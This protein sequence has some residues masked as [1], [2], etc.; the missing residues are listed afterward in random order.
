MTIQG[1]KGTFIGQISH[2]ST[3]PASIDETAKYGLNMVTLGLTPT[4]LRNTTAVNALLAKAKGYGIKVQFS[5]NF[6]KEL[7]SDGSSGSFNDIQNDPVQ[8][9]N[10]MSTIQF[11]LDN[12]SNMSNSN[13]IAG[14]EL[15]EP[16]RHF[17]ITCNPALSTYTQ[18]MTDNRALMDFYNTMFLEIKNKI[19]TARLSA[20][21][22]YGFNHASS[23]ASWPKMGTDAAFI[24]ANK[25]FTF[26]SIQGASDN[27]TAV[28]DM[29]AQIRAALTYPE[30]EICYTAMLT[31]STFLKN[32]WPGYRCGASAPGTDPLSWANP[33]CWN[34]LVFEH[35]KYCALNN[36]PFS[37]FI[38]ERF[39]VLREYWTAKAICSTCEQ[40]YYYDKPTLLP[41]GTTAGEI[42]KSIINSS[43]PPCPTLTLGAITIDNITCPSPIFTGTHILNVIPTGGQGTLKYNWTVNNTSIGTSQS[44]S[45]N[46]TIDGSYTISV[47]VTDSCNPIQSKTSTCSINVQHPCSPLSLGAITIGS[48]I[49]P[50]PVFMG[51]HTFTVTPIG[52]EGTLSYKWTVDNTVIGTTQTVQWSATTIGTYTIAVT[53]TDS[54]NPSQS[55]TISCSIIVQG[56]CPTLV[57]VLTVPL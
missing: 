42:I 57:T 24:T 38:E 50:T 8:R 28:Q 56:P 14:F 23:T 44:V 37:T 15:E 10:F 5:L 40:G 7:E 19:G 35:I 17:A 25:I 9:A 43:I 49:C 39:N 27:P 33:I 11:V 31:T 47:T 32:V 12:Y 4:E 29:I 48:S 36:I 26:Y 21:F 41:S 30:L 22:N 51:I 2:L 16:Y 54:C 55:K 18:C 20:G 13:H 53:V 6:S 3:M 45:W 46:P 1:S 52:G 34:Q